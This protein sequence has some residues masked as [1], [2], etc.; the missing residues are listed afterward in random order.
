MSELLALTAAGATE[1]VRTGELSPSEIWDVYRGRAAADDLNAFTWVAEERPST[2]DK[3]TRSMPFRQHF[4]NRG[5]NRGRLRFK[6]EG[7]T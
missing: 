3:I 4:A 2:S 1:R 7:M 5:L 6:L